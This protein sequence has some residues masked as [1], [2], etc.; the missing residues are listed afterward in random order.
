MGSENGRQ[1]RTEPPLTQPQTTDKIAW[2][3]DKIKLRNLY[4]ES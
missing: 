4:I 3:Q 1:R 2:I